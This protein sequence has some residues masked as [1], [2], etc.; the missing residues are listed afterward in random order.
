MPETSTISIPG[1]DRKDRFRALAVTLILLGTLLAASAPYLYGY[2][3][4][5]PSTRFW[6]VP[7]VNSGDA[8]QYLA[9]TRITSEGHLLVGDPFTSEPHA[10]RL[11]L[12]QAVFQGFLCRLSGWTPIEAFQA[13]RVL[14][15]AALL[16]SGWWFGTLLLPR[17]RQRWLFLGLL[18]F[19]AGAGWLVDRLGWQVRHG[20][21]YQPEGNTFYLL[22][23]LPHLALSAA[24]LTA[25]FATL[26]GVE[27]AF[28]RSGVQALKDAGADPLNPEPATREAGT[29]LNPSYTPTPQHLNTSTP[30][31]QRLNAR[32]PERLNTYPWLAA[33]LALSLLLSWTHPFDFLTLG[34]GLGAYGLVRWISCRKVPRASLL[35]F[36]A[37]VLGAIPAALYLAWVTRV[38]PLYAALA[39]DPL[40][41]QDFLYYAIP[42]GPLVLA[43]L[44][45][46]FHLQLRRRYALPLCWVI[47]AFLFLLTPFRLGGK[48]PRVLGGI[49]VPLALL[50][51]VGVDYAARRIGISLSRQNAR[52]RRQKAEGRRQKAEG[53]QE[54]PSALSP[55]HLNTSTPQHLNAQRP[56]LIIGAAYFLLLATGTW[57]MLERQT[58]FY[59]RR[60]PDFY[61][62]PSV[63]RLFEYLDR[64]GN[65]GQVTLGG[66]YT[67]GWAPT[68]ADT[69]VYYGHW[70]M[71]LNPQVK[72]AELSWF[73]TEIGG[74]FNTPELKAEWLRKRGITWVIWY[75]W[76]WRADPV[77][78]EAIPGLQLVYSTPE[79]YLY[80]YSK[81]GQMEEGVEPRRHGEE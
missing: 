36:G 32:T 24:L 23:N 46:L 11:F 52:G 14:S 40:K 61:M 81:E 7:P 63:Q 73:F 68:W 51:T 10:S 71:T 65:R 53:I 26:P 5:P 1:P 18:C 54:K 49:H 48:Q 59:A 2:A 29:R 19:S 70:H 20:D 60:R 47:C 78:L 21:F 45:V 4:R 33:T 28:R 34:L 15:G 72:W 56:T 62:S 58:R 43:G 66:A 55:Q 44:V 9:F 39:D 16:L 8:N 13:S 25:L 77:P 38:E 30:A 12:P 69:R 76:E 42:H 27:G 50:A 80:R 64:H 3:I 22:G 17:W 67:G 41:V 75:P 6:A 57:G 37:L 79:V 74:P 31:P 35:H